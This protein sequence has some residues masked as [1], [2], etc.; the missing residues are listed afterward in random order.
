M[1]RK[2]IVV[3]AAYGHDHIA[4]LGG[5]SAVLPII[6]AAGAD[7]VEIRRELLGD[8]SNSALDTLA[9]AIKTHRLMACYSAPQ[10]LYLDNARLN[11]AIPALLEETRRLNAAWLKLSL[12]HYE[13]SQQFSTLQ[14]WL[15]KSGVQLVIEND[16]TPAGRLAP[17]QR[18]AAACRVLNM[19][20][21]LTFD[22]ANWLW[23]DES[24]ERAAQILAP[25]VGYIHVKA[26]VTDEHGTRAIALDD[27]DPRWLA[28]LKA[29]PPD[30]PRG[31]EFPLQGAD[32]TGV[33]RHYVTQLRKE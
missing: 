30:A 32:L 20:L 4:K 33:T 31:I 29:L 12:G 13:S 16:Q 25:A 7:G 5:Q 18:F 26:A 27:A 3:T 22:M 15:L 8:V 21:Q 14:Q 23:V 19:P 6:A 17:M 2:I 9:Q 11:P 28:L 10:A 1:E 24:P